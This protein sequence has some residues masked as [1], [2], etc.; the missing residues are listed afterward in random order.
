MKKIR[1][2]GSGSSLLMETQKL[3]SLIKAMKVSTHLP[4]SIKIRVEGRSNDFF[5]DDLIKM[6]QDSGLDFLT[7]HGRHWTETL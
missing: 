2:K 6:I 5:H 4:V 1:R 3:A 7:V